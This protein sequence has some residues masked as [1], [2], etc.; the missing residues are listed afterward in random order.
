MNN[1]GLDKA[2]A[3]LETQLKNVAFGEISITLVVH[4]GEIRRVVK[5]I[6]ESEKPGGGGE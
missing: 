1:P 3:W 6:S 4:N 5:T 2:T